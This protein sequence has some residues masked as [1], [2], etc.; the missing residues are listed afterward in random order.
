[1]TTALQALLL[2]SIGCSLCSAGQAAMLA[3]ANDQ[4]IITG[5]PG[6]ALVAMAVWT[7]VLGLWP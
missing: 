4:A 1:M 6:V 5:A 3:G 7:P 2:F